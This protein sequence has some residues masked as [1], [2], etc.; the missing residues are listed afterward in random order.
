MLCVSRAGQAGFV[1]GFG[2]YDPRNRRQ[3]AMLLGSPGRAGC[4]WDATVG[5]RPSGIARTRPHGVNA[6]FIL[7]QRDAAQLKLIMK[8]G[9]LPDALEPGS[10]CVRTPTGSR[11]SLRQNAVDPGFHCVSAGLEHPDRKAD[12]AGVA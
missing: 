3:I 1:Y 11:D 2:C 12:G 7:F 8:I 10:H 9:L 6:A 4:G 5:F